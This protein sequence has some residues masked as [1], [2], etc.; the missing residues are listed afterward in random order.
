[1]YLGLKINDT[2]SMPIGI[3]QRATKTN[4]QSGDI[5]AVCLPKKIA[6]A[7]LKSGYLDSGNCPGHA[8]AILK[9]VIAVPGDTVT[10]TSKAIIVNNRTHYF[11]PHQSL[12]HEHHHIKQWISYGS[13]YNIKGY[14]LYG[15]NDPIYSWDSRYYGSVLPEKI[16]NSYQIWFTT[17]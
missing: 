5:V 16:Q 10:L 1:K 2:S 8:I 14:W 17:T 11:T 13:R 4:I 15:T 3:Y 7:G 9:T 12:D 6:E